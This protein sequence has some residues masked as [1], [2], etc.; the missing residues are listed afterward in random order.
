M[1]SL[2]Q[3]RDI[4][5]ETLRFLGEEPSLDPWARTIIDRLAVPGDNEEIGE[6]YNA[7]NKVSCGAGRAKTRVSVLEALDLLPAYRNAMSDAHGSIK[8]D[9]TTYREMT[10]VL[11]SLARTLL[12][13]GDLLG[14][15]RLVYAEEVKVGLGG[16]KRVVWMDLM[17]ATAVRRQPYEGVEVS[18]EILPG[19][20]YLEI[21]SDAWLSLHPLLCYHSGEVVDQVFFL[22]RARS[23]K[24]GIQFLCYAT[25]DFYL[26]GRDPVGD[27]LVR[28]LEEL[29]SWVTSRD[30]NSVDR[31]ALA[32]QSQAD[33]QARGEVAAEEAEPA[34]A[35]FGDFEILGELGRGGMAVVYLAK[36]RSLGRTVALKVLPPS[37]HDNSV[38]LARF[39]QEVRALS[40]CDS[41]NVVKILSSGEAEGT[42]YYAMEYI[43]GVDLGAIG[44]TLASYHSSGAGALREGHFAKAA[45]TVLDTCVGTGG[46]PESEPVEAE[47]LQDFTSGRDISFRLAGAIR[48]AALGAHHIHDHGIIHRDLKP[49]N[50]M[51]TRAELRPV[52]MDLGLAKVAEVSQSITLD[53]GGILGT[54]RYMPPEQLQRNLLEVD[55]RADVYALGAVLYEF[56]CRRPMLEGD[57]EERLTT[58]VL[59]EEPPRPQDVNPRLPTDLAT[60]IVKATKKDPRERYGS[61]AEFADDLDRFVHG[62]AVARDPRRSGTSSRSM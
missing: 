10:P 20:V 39:R 1:P 38:A 61:A 31:E 62:E 44:K 18:E 36:Q 19:R 47:D 35:I 41:P 52:V 16:E 5:R 13:D 11:L 33:A 24:G 57:T 56:A 53:K 32:A 14:G 22:N 12:K 4:F 27:Y 50:I 9:P 17:G 8:A 34:G 48:D 40:R 15:G 60:V 49:Q 7:L 2:G 37:L 26:P 30:V 46:L 58:Q 59:F 21:G 29:L 55:A 54:L 45:S 28:D 42:L 6:A 23:G 25:G 3:W 51:I 43:D